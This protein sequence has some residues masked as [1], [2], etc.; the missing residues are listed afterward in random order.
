[1]SIL[2]PPNAVDVVPFAARRE[3]ITPTD[4][5]VWWEDP[6]DLFQIV[7]EFASGMTPDP[8][9]V[10]LEY[11]Q[12]SWPRVRVPKG[13]A[14]GAGH[15][16]WLAIDDWTNGRWQVADCELV[17]QGF[18]WSYTFRPLNAREFPDESDFPATFRRTLKLALRCA[19]PCQVQT[20][21]AYTDS[22][23][24]EIEIA[25]EWGAQGDAS[26]TWDGRLEAYNGE[27]LTIWPL[28]SST[29]VASP[30]VW[31]STIDGGETGGIV[32]RVRYA[33]NEDLNSYDRTI[34]TVRAKAHSFSFA[35][36]DVLAGEPIY[37]RDFGVL[38]S[39]A[40]ARVRLREFVAAWKHRHSKTIYQ[41]VVEM[42]E[43]S[44][45]RAWSDMPPKR[46][47]YFVLG[48]EGGRQK[49]GVDP[50]G[51][52]F[53][54]ENFIR[55]VPGKDT[56]R[57][58][59]DGQELRFRF[60][61]PIA[62]PGDRSLLDGY[63]PIIRTT[64]VQGDLCYEQE[65][66]A[67]WLFGDIAS[68]HMGDDPVVAMVR[69]RLTNLSQEPVR[70]SLPLASQV[71]QVAELLTTRDGLILAQTKAGERLRYLF[72]M[73]GAGVLHPCEDGFTYEVTLAGKSSHTIYV[74]IPFV[75]LAA[76][77]EIVRLRELEYEVEK[78]HV[79]E[80][81]RRR[82]AQ[83]AQI[84]TP[85]ATLNDFYR[86][87]LMHMLIV[88]D[89]EPGS[90]RMVARCGGFRYGSFPDEGCMVI[91]DLDRR[92]YTKEAERCLQLYV[93]YQG[94]VPLP[95]NYQSAEG[96]FYGSGGYEMAGYNRNQGWVLWCLAEHYRYT[97]D[98]E[99]LKR[100]A[101][102]L[103]KGCEWI[104][105]E[106]QATMKLD[107]L[108]KRPIHYGFLPPGSLED[109]TDYWTWLSTN[110]YAYLGFRA[111]ADVLAEIGHPE[112]KR[113]QE[114]AVAYGR[115]LRAGFFEACV[116]SPVVRLRD[117][118]WVPHFP[119]RLERRGRDFGWLRE[120]LEGAVHLV[121]CGLIAPDELA[122]RWIIED[123][124][125]NLFLSERYGYQP[126]DFERQWFSWGGFSMQPNLLIF[127]LLYLWRDEPE[128]Y[129]RVY[130]NS[131]AAAFY[132]DTRMLTEHPLPTLADWMGDHFKSS[133]EANSTYWLRLMFLAE[134]GD[135]LFVGQAIPR[136]WFEEGKT[137]RVTKA[138]THFGE[139]SL[140]IVSQVA[141]GHIVVRLDPP[142]RNP[143]R[144]IRLRVR[145]PQSLPIRRVW[146]NGLPHREFHVTKEVIDLGHVTE[147]VEV[148]VGY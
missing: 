19:T 48:C 137:M 16:G 85:N 72:D 42:P 49:F 106:R 64:W 94:T 120:V 69:F 87:H 76:S 129:L 3:W 147:A 110:A 130:F 55:R 123:Y 112:G 138:L 24:R 25:I 14:V 140:E 142:R 23:W 58:G 115:D 109:V 70:V 90:D 104:I 60:G 8:K 101:P 21:R 66:Y 47:F 133:D 30:C 53:L 125:D 50:S 131:F 26:A 82:I 98:R 113:L 136:A 88:N 57:L 56:P 89:R 45:E 146:V 5:E 74:K 2:L 128:H 22:E 119:S 102:A 126:E 96:V 12:H 36:D 81:W 141:T 91:S 28:T 33:Y 127:P 38:V 139:T 15:G 75:Q 39:R 61:L 108:G 18:L 124:E 83:G 93:D 122:A 59:W 52:I 132:P 78:A 43:Q 84:E 6:R 135:E 116:R 9:D 121:Y 17:Q 95:G 1:M 100:V 103:V 111:A 68:E 51:D 105:R 7:I 35:V 31:H 77:D 4:Y 40:D 46:R 144:Q 145:H 27:I 80:F 73:N 41:R 54:A 117:G 71:D 10:R 34:V 37:I 79:I 32:A 20:L 44:W 63:L 143:P 86:T 67:I 99:W 65:A 148:R 62:E 134:H 92:G 97:R 11:W 107:A 29:I 13:A 118:T 114:E